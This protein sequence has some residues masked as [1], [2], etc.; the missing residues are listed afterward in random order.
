MARIIGN[1]LDNVLNG[2][3]FADLFFGYGGN[4]KLYGFSGNDIMYAGDGH[5][6]LFG[7]LGDDQMFGGDGADVMIGG[8]GNDI[9]NGGTGPDMVSFETSLRGVNVN[10][11]PQ[12]IALG[13]AT[14]GLTTRQ[15][16]NEGIDTFYSIEN[17]KGSQFADR[18]SGDQ[19]GN[20]LNG[21]GG[22]D[23]LN[24]REGDD[25]LLGADGNDLLIGG[26]G[27]DYFFGGNDYDTASFAS[28]TSAVRVDLSLGRTAQNTG[29]GL[30]RFEL[31]E[32][33]TGSAFGDT[34]Q[35]DNGNNVIRGG[36]GNDY[37]NGDDS[38][39]GT[40]V[41][42]GLRI[43][44][45]GGNDVLDGGYGSDVLE[46]GAGIDSLTGGPDRDTFVFK[47]AGNIWNPQTD[48]ITDFSFRDGDQIDLR[49][50]PG[51]DS[52]SQLQI[53]TVSLW[54]QSYTQIIY[55]ANDKILLEGA[56]VIIPTEDIM[57]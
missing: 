36:V 33:L 19:F 52:Y 20:V 8:Q 23:T 38:D 46:G 37:I 44:K 35:G 15:N 45:T 12:L 42:N 31:V 13:P 56:P 29:E 2:T 5:D 7:G 16:T 57:I 21:D 51:L 53:S 34:L 26:L 47:A 28:S 39:G 25:Y 3:N 27:N 50:V 9:Y 17:L 49:Y 55:D 11:E 40:L 48:Y 1:N 43:Y 30:D 22:S 18:L 14:T 54:G 10:L 41:V 24:G 4:D 6:Q 32:N